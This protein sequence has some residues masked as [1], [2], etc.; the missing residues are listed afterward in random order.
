MAYFSVTDPEYRQALEFMG[1]HKTTAVL[2]IPP[3]MYNTMEYITKT[4]AAKGCESGGYFEVIQPFGEDVPIFET[5]R[6]IFPKQTVSGARVDINLPHS[7]ELFKEIGGDIRERLVQWHSHANFAVFYS[8]TDMNSQNSSTEYGFQ[9]QYRIFLVTNSKGELLCNIH[10]YIP[11]H[12][13]AVCKVIIA[14]LEERLDNPADTVALDAEMAILITGGGKP[15]YAIKDREEEVGKYIGGKK[16]EDDNRVVGPNNGKF[17]RDATGNTAFKSCFGKSRGAEGTGW[18][19]NGTP[20]GS[21]NF[22]D[23]TA[24]EACFKHNGQDECRDIKD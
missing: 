3:V 20:R 13:V 2:L 23:T 11:V 12:T 21:Y 17:G 1:E 14:P 24:D 22:R 5:V 16:Q 6:H 8:P 7:E 15:N 4:Y 18:N 10:G 9:S 19:S